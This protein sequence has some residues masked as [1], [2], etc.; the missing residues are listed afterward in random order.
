MLCISLGLHCLF[1]VHWPT[2]KE[3][4]MRFCLFSQAAAAGQSLLASRNAY[5]EAFAKEQG[6]SSSLHRTPLP[7]MLHEEE[8]P[9]T[10]PLSL[11][12]SAR[13]SWDMAWS[14]DRR[15]SGFNDSDE[16]LIFLPLLADGCSRSARA[17]T[18]P[19]ARTRA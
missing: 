12:G 8:A 19:C 1:N 10:R 17:R 3:R 6:V 13:P 4:Y 16:D 15:L 14:L 7:W 5:K 2:A 11:D 9:I 18:L